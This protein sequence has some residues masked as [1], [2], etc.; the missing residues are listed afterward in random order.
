M[1]VISSVIIAIS[2]VSIYEYYSNRSWQQVTSQSRNN[3]VF[4]KRNKKYGAYTIRRDYDKRILLILLSF[5]SSIGLSYG[6]YIFMKNPKIEFNKPIKEDVYINTVIDLNEN[7]EEKKEI[8]K[9]P[10]KTKPV[11][12]I[13]NITPIVKDIIKTDS[14]KINDDLKD[15]NTGA[16]TIKGD[17]T[18]FEKKPI[19]DGSGEGTKTKTVIPTKGPEEFPDVDAEFPGGKDARTMFIA[20]RIVFPDEGLEKGGKCYLQFVVDENGEISSVKVLNGV[21]DC[22]ECDKEAIKVIKAMPRWKPGESKGQKVSSYF[23]M[24][25]HFEPQE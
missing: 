16:E 4:E 15:K 6:A 19:I 18:G 3:V 20:K 14:V 8:K 13:A 17:S 9:E 10:K 25:I 22:K 23:R 5:I 21:P 12:Q 2:A 11:E 1:V 24:V 7:K